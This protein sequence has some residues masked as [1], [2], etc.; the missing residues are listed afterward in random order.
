MDK[1]GQKKRLLWRDSLGSLYNHLY[2]IAIMFWDK[3]VELPFELMAI[4]E[5]RK[6]TQAGNCIWRR[7]KT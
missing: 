2:F 4:F 1:P 3:T 5:F 6:V 7:K